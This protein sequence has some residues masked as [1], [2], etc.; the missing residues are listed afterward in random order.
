M[1]N[2]LDNFE[3]VILTGHPPVGRLINYAEVRLPNCFYHA[4]CS[5]GGFE[6]TPKVCLLCQTNITFR[7]FIGY[8][9]S[10]CYV[11]VQF[12]AYANQISAKG[13]FNIKTRSEKIGNLGN[14]L[15]LAGVRISPTRTL[16]LESNSTPITGH[17]SRL[18]SCS[19]LLQKQTESW[20][21]TIV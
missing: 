15:P 6:K 1:P 5:C 8:T 19:C 16:A 12:H 4:Q 18:S 21:G 7:S 17:F 14:H 20:A 13:R 3:A 11:V 2:F 9:S 10:H